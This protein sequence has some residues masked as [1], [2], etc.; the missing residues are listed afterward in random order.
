MHIS[1][2][3]GILMCDANLAVP[4]SERHHRDDK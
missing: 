4:A 1:C 3:T 2:L